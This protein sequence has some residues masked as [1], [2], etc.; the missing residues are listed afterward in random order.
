MGTKD[1]SP[2]NW[3]RQILVYSKEINVVSLDYAELVKEGCYGLAVYNVHTISSCLAKLI[4]KLLEVDWMTPD[5]LHVIGHGLGAH[6]AGQL[7]NYVNQ[8]LKHITGLDPL[9]AE[10]HKLHKRAKLDKDDAEFVDVI[11]TDPFERGMLL[12]VGH[13]DF[14][15]NPAMAYQTGC[16]S[17]ITRSLCNHE[18][19]S[20]LYAQS[21]LSSIGFW[22]KKCEN[23]IKYAEKD[24]GQHIY[25]VMG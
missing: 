11:H 21:V 13:A 14:Y 9:S 19:A 3:L 4:D 1:T 23:M 18:R 8:K 24:C 2:N 6:V 12:P 25:A 16:E 5:K 17:P 22:G 10:F 15:P 7:S 20:Q